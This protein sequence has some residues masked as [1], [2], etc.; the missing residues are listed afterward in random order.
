MK[1]PFQ[2]SSGPPSLLPPKIGQGGAFGHGSQG[3]A[4]WTPASAGPLFWFDGDLSPRVGSSPVTS[5]GDAAGS[6][7]TLTVG[8]TKPTLSATLLNGHRGMDLLPATQLIQTTGGVTGTAAWTGYSVGNLNAVSSSTYGNIAIFGNPLANGLFA[9]NTIGAAYGS[10]W[11]GGGNG[12]DAQP[13]GGTADTSTHVFHTAYDGTNRILWVDGVFIAL[14]P[15][16]MAM[17]S[18]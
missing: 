18:G 8:T 3:G 2:P 10:V 7:Q 4:I 16:V 12:Q 13:Q 14:Y 5:I 11:W 6:G 9:S 1:W 17:T 15:D